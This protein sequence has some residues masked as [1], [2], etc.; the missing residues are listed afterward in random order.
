MNSS[1]VI[2]V[3]INVKPH[4]S[5]AYYQTMLSWVLV[6][7]RAYHP[8]L[9]GLIFITYHAGHSKKNYYAVIPVILQ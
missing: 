1:T 6:L 7:P 9:P 8:T 4:I 5:L 3:L 2:I